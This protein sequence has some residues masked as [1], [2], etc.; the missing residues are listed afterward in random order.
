MQGIDH[1]R[2]DLRHI[3]G[4]TLKLVGTHVDIVVRI[5]TV[6]DNAFVANEV[7]IN[8]NGNNRV[9]RSV[10]AGRA[11][12]QPEIIVLGTDDVV[13][14]IGVDKLRVISDIAWLGCECVQSLNAAMRHERTRRSV[15]LGRF[16][17][18]GP[19]AVSVPPQDGIVKPQGR[20]R[21]AEEPASHVVSGI[22]GECTI[23]HDRGSRI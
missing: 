15:E 16:V 23:G 2:V 13:R 20:C 18:I 6:V 22:P 11:G 19:R 10:N 4:C 12:V 9:V 7:L 5:N 14:T 8:I 21:V 1:F 3:N 17:R